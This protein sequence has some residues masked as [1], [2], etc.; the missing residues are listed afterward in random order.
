[1]SPSHEKSRLNHILCRISCWFQIWP[2]FWPQR[3]HFRAQEQFL[4]KIF[5]TVLSFELASFGTF[6]VWGFQ[7]LLSERF[8]LWEDPEGNLDKFKTLTRYLASVLA[9]NTN[10]FFH[11]L[12]VSMAK[13]KIKWESSWR[14]AIPS[15][16]YD[17]G[18][19]SE[20]S[21]TQFSKTIKW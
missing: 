6:E 16:C 10:F 13:S 11:F 3:L 14:F 12:D 8:L 15:P 17:F 21:L 1:M 18:N 4:D 5:L 20:L 9:I 2:P 19:R 7:H